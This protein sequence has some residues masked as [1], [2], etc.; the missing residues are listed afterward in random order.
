MNG[1]RPFH[2]TN[3]GNTVDNLP[4][5]VAMCCRSSAPPEAEGSLALAARCSRLSIVSG[6]MYNHE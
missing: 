4:N 5:I 1:L 3:T 6:C 2:A